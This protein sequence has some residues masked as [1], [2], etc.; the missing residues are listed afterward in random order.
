MKSLQQVL[1]TA[2][3]V[4]GLSFAA[5][6]MAVDLPFWN[7]PGFPAPSS[8][9]VAPTTGLGSFNGT[10]AVVPVGISGRWYSLH[11]PPGL[12]PGQ[13][14][15]LLIDLHGAGESE[16]L[17]EY[18]T[19]WSVYAN[20]KKFIVAYGQALGTVMGGTFWNA[21]SEH[22]NDEQYL[23]DV[24]E[25]ISAKYC[26]DAKRVYVE[27]FSNGGVMAQRAACDMAD[28]V[29][30]VA[31]H[32]GA[33][34]TMLGAACNPIRPIGVMMSAGDVDPT[35]FTQ[36]DEQARAM[37][38]AKNGCSTTPVSSSD[39]YGTTD[40]HGGC[41]GGVRVDWRILT[42]TTHQWPLGA[43]QTDLHNRIWNFL[44][45]HTLP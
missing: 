36:Y 38:I 31:S 42:N 20:Q 26:V 23:R 43:G 10:L 41:S 32:A 28:T 12:T 1:R 22:G 8:C 37:W 7:L 3:A 21:Y 9:S 6:S 24:I 15:P 18:Q 17:A 45:S 27:G 33:T 5:P 19:G 39:S 30:A 11:V 4:I 16:D 2:C 35:Q 44:T 13:K 29:A 40:S 25:H 34:P 14:V